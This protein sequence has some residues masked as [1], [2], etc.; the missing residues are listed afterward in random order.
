M[1]WR[2]VAAFAAGW[3]ATLLDDLGTDDLATL[4]GVGDLRA[5]AEQPD[6]VIAVYPQ[7][8]SSGMASCRTSAGDLC[9]LHG[10]QADV[11]SQGHVCDGRMIQ[12]DGRDQEA[13][14]RSVVWDL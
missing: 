12:R 6:C 10:W 7:G 3:Q 8:A 11:L 4:L 2:A 5:E 1:P 9:T 13:T 14:H